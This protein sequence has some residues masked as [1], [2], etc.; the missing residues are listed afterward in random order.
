MQNPSR[1]KLLLERRI[2]RI[3]GVLG[4]LFIV[5]VI[6]IAE[7]LIEAVNRRQELISFRPLQR[8]LR[9]T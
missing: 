7:E 2:L 4:F 3:V 9:P 8:P 5:E 1:S 6:E